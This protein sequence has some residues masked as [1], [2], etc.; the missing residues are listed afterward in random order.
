MNKAIQDMK[1]RIK[2]NKKKENNRMQ[3]KLNKNGI[4]ADI[5]DI[6]SY[7]DD[8]SGGS[9][10]SLKTLFFSYQPLSPNPQFSEDLA[11]TVLT[12]DKVE[13]SGTLL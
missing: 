8:H 3:I 12:T 4:K 11:N 6:K 7:I 1:N 13:P 10:P 9:N 2:E 5:K